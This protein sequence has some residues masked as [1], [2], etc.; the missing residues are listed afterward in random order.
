MRILFLNGPNLNMLGRREPDIYGTTT[1]DG[2]NNQLQKLAVFYQIEVEF[3]QS[4]DEGALIDILQ[5]AGWSRNTDCII[6][7][8]GALTHYSY[9]L[10]DAVASLPIPVIEVHLSNIYQRESFRQQSVIAPVATG[11]ITGFGASS[12]IAAF[13][14]A[15]DLLGLDLLKQRNEE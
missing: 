9:A 10:R 6:F 1:L 4:N 14:V 7:N 3:A 15:L 2:I 13:F 12:Y 8:P 5:Q 11:Q